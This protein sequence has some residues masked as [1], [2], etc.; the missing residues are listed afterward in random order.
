MHLL[1]IMYSLNEYDESGQITTRGIFLNLGE[2]IKVYIADN[3]EQFDQLLDHLHR[4]RDDIAKY[5]E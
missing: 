3:L 1:D 4:M 2:D 5:I